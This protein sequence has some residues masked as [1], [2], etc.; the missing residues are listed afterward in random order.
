MQ[1]TVIP[2]QYIEGTAIDISGSTI[3]GAYTAGDG[4]SI[5]GAEISASGLSVI[6]YDNGDHAV[7]SGSETLMKTFTLSAN[8]VTQKLI[9]Y[10]LSQYRQG[11]GT[12]AKTLGTMGLW[13]GTN[14]T[15][16]GAGNTNVKNV[17]GKGGGIGASG[18][19]STSGGHVGLAH[20]I[21]SSD[22]TMTSTWYVHIT[23]TDAG[24]YD[25]HNITLKQAVLVG[26]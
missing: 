10:A 13:I 7:T 1:V 16:N 24:T 18:S 25:D 26:L 15:F 17:S 5:A 2:R 12:G 22:V 21:T 8:E 9:V 6:Q 23:G 14:S 19:A 20:V 3:S 4:I 11:T